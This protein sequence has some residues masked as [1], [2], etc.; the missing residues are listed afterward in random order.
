M[1][2]SPHEE[3]I[4]EFPCGCVVEQ[5]QTWEEI[6]LLADGPHVNNVT[7]QYTVIRQCKVFRKDIAHTQPGL[8]GVFENLKHFPGAIVVA[9]L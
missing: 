9:Q 8:W 2:E 1:D 7:K 6:V 3:I 5:M 4:L